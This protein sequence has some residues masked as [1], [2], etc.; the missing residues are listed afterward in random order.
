M[1]TR[2]RPY[3]YDQYISSRR[4]AV[5][6]FD[7]HEKGGGEWVVNSN[8][9]FLWYANWKAHRFAQYSLAVKENIKDKFV[10]RLKSGDEPDN[11]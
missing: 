8:H 10:R 3:Q 2:V 7:Q 1:K 11:E 9:R 6:I 4:W 5:E